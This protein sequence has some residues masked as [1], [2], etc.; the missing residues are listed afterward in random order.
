MVTFLRSNFIPDEDEDETEVEAEVGAGSLVAVEAG[1]GTE[2]LGAVEAGV[3]AGALVAV[4]AGF[5]AG[6]EIEVGV[7]DEVDDKI[8]AARVVFVVSFIK[9]Q[10]AVPSFRTIKLSTALSITMDFT[11]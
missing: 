11:S 7:D 9:S 6:A 2:A 3:G 10:F 1:V 4:E 5:G 8:V